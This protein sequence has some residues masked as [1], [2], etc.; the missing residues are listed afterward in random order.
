MGLSNILFTIVLLGSLL[1]F[2]FSAR[3][4]LSYLQVGKSEDRFDRPLLRMQRVVKIALL[5][6]KLLREPL[7]GF[8]HL[9][10]FWGFLALIGAV[11]E[12]IG[13]GVTGHFS[14]RFLGGLYS[15]ITFTQEIF[16]VLVVV[17]VAL[18]LWRRFIVPVIRL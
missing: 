12:S 2:G 14:F 11:V 18:A 6:T 8:M 5:Q 17:S 4:L 15:F 9:A 3:R 13:E 1:F 7:A 10:I 16:C